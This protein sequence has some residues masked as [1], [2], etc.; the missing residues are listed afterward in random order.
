MPVYARQ[1]GFSTFVVGSIYSILPIL[2]L[3]AKPLFGALA[4]RYQRHKSMFIFFI[5][6]TI[7]S[8]YSINFIKPIPKETQIVYNCNDDFSDLKFC[9]NKP[10]YCATADLLNYTNT[11]SNKTYHFDVSLNFN[12]AVLVA[13]F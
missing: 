3:I 8:F 10:D 2:G 11:L 4:D 1:L 13:F 6:L 7:I 9:M 5:L 12:Y